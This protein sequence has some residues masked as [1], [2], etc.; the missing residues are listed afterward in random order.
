MTGPDERERDPANTTLSLKFLDEFIIPE[1]FEYEGTKVG[2]LSDLDYDGHYFYAVSDHMVNP[3][4]YKF[5]IDF[6]EYQLDTLRFE[7]VLLIPE[8]LTDSLTFDSEGVIYDRQTKR[9]TIGSEGRNKKGKNGF[10][11]ELDEDLRLTEL[12]QAPEYF[13]YSYEGGPQNNA[14]F[15]GL[16]HS[17]DNR[18]IWVSVELPLKMD[19]SPDDSDPAGE[20]IRITHFDKATKRPT[21][22]FGYKLHGFEKKIIADGTYGVSAI[23]EYRPKQFFVLERAFIMQSE[24]FGFQARLYKVDAREASNTLEIQD[25]Y[26]KI[27]QEVIPAKSN[28]LLDLKTIR[29]ELPS[30]IIDNLEGMSFGPE[31]PNGNQ[32]LLFVSDN[33][34]NSFYNQLNQV[35]VFEIVED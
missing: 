33:N 28:L 20:F 1:D 5:S 21:E 16:S 23:L 18:G 7:E 3:R 27:G 17:F 30:R 10:I 15:E 2:G 9:Y 11:A 8:S 12:Y 24:D 6:D 26:S 34:F 32:T 31:L 25:L 19:L 22:Q 29:S 4:I 35:L 14:L 13:K